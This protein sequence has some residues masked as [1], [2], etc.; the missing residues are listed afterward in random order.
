VF[1]EARRARRGVVHVP[2]AGLGEGRPSPRRR[3]SSRSSAPTG[4]A[5]AQEKLNDE[6]WSKDLAH[7]LQDPLLTSV[8]ATILPAVLKSRGVPQ[9]PTTSSPRVPIDPATDEGRGRADHPLRRGHLG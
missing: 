2:G 8:F 7:P 4:P 6:R 5:A 9:R 1:T 3:A